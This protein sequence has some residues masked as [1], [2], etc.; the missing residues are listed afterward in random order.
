MSNKL[1][2][3]PDESLDPALLGSER[4]FLNKVFLFAT[5][6]HYAA[7]NVSKY[8]G[9]PYINH[10][11][12]VAGILYEVGITDYQILSAALLHDVVEDT[13]VPLLLLQ[14]LFGAT[15]ASLTDDLTDVSKPE[16]GNR[17]TRKAIDREHTAKA[18]P[19]AKSIKLADLISNSQNIVQ[20]DP[21]FAKVYIPEKKLL[22]PHLKEGNAELWERANKIVEDYERAH[23]L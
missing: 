12:E 15:I 16:D 7:G 10:P 21:A 23:P 8:T 3:G 1:F 20:W 2:C 5:A 9:E 19:R 14:Q 4:S 13:A 6:A 22:L 18:D 17:A 11:K